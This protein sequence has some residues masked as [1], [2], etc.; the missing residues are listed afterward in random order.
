MIPYKRAGY[1]YKIII[2]RGGMPHKFFYV[3]SEK[4]GRCASDGHTSLKNFF[5]H[6]F[7]NRLLFLGL[8]LEP[9]CNE[10]MLMQ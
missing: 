9:E 6:Y 10:S 5:K 8:Y 3:L 4:W 1:A 7:C 2:N